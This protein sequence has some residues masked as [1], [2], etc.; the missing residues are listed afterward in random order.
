MASFSYDRA[1][2]SAKRLIDRFGQVGV[3]RRVV[4]QGGGPSD[5]SGGIEN[6]TEAPVSLVVLPID[7]K[8]V[9]EDMDGATIKTTDVQIY[10]AAAGL[11]FEPATTD[12]IVSVG[13]TYKVL[14]CNAL[15]PAGQAVIFD[16][17]GRA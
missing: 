12:H 7:A 14:R 13:G 11:E 8:Q 5:P 17:I 2:A 10:V 3:L 6:I 4:V 9:G 1:A 15:A 16:I